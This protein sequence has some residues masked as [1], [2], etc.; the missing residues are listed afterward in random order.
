[1]VLEPFKPSRSLCQGDPLSPYLFLF[2]ADGLSKLIQ[3]EVSNNH[4]KELKICRR[5]P[6]ISHLLF[7]DGTLL[8]FEAS[9]DQAVMLGGGGVMEKYEKGTGQLINPVK[10]SLLFNSECSEEDK[11]PVMH[12]LQVRNTSA[13]GKYLG[14]P[15][16]EERMGKKKF[17]STKGRLVKRCSGWAEKNMSSDA[18]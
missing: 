15:T 11:E 3:Q 10:S 1:V 18:K 8:F 12:T 13:G 9:A 16:P 17:R 14:L 2:V 4:L 5:S 6:G 7:A